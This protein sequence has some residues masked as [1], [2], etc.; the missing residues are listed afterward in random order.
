[1]IWWREL[2]LPVLSFSPNGARSRCVGV[3]RREP[4]PPPRSRITTSSRFRPSA[5]TRIGTAEGQRTLS[6]PRRSPIRH[7]YEKGRSP[8]E[9]ITIRQWFIKTMSSRRVAGSRPRAAWHPPYMQ[10]RLENWI[11]LAGDLCLPPAV[12]RRS[13]PVWYKVARRSIDFARASPPDRF[14]W[15]RPPPMPHATSGQRNPPGLVAILTSG[16]VGALAPRPRCR[17]GI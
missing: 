6:R 13:F 15:T 1:M 16:T 2:A 17:G 8:F 4:R 7:F 14:R 12:F 5:R 3:V 11:R 10:S 9:N